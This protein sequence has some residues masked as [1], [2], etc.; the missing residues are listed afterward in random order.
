MHRNF[1][2]RSFS[3]GSEVLGG[4]GESFT[5]TR[6]KPAQVGQVNSSMYKPQNTEGK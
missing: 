5:L 2:P 1:F 3:I 4:W 6:L